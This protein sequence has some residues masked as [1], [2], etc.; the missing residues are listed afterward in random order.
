MFT[1]PHRNSNQRGAASLAVSIVLLF[2]MT[3]IAFFASRS[4]IFEQ[5][6]S[7][8][9]YRAARAF[10][11]A[12][13]GIEW[14]LTQINQKECVSATLAAGVCNPVGGVVSYRDR[15]IAPAA[16]GFAP[17]GGRRSG[18][19]LSTDAATRVVS[20]NCNAPTSNTLALGGAVTDPRFAIAWSAGPDPR[21]VQ[22]ISTGCLGQGAP[23]DGTGTPDAVSV[24]RV[25]LRVS[26]ELPSAPGAGLTTGGVA[27]TAGSIKVV[28][29]D[30]LS[31]G[32][33]INSGSAVAIASGVDLVTIEGS[34][35][36]A[37]VLDNDTALAALA[38][39]PDL[40]FKQYF[41]KIPS[42][43]RND[44]GTFVLNGGGSAF[45]ASTPTLTCSTALNCGSAVSYYM[46]RGQDKFW[47]QGDVAF[48]AS[49]MPSNFGGYLGDR[50][51]PLYLA[52]SGDIG[53][54]A[55]ITAFGLFYAST[56]TAAGNTDPTGTGSATIFGALVTNGNFC[57]VNAGGNCA[58]PG[59]GG[60]GAGNL[61]VVYD[62]LTL[63]SGPPKGLL[64]RVPG[65][66]RDSGINEL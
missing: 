61:T 23:C 66:W 12:E 54:N 57:K 50:Q 20:L 25:L 45:A 16:G 27:I 43:W 31:N 14:A 38:T 51:R 1:S 22:L 11:T 39:D 34:S 32:I 13:A 35:L 59:A 24:V 5:R 56:L 52:S 47:V 18:C 2:G 7:A 62:P 58:S 40:F 9:Q 30:K 41:G 42:D 15:Y 65:S 64:V 49:T 46:D 63:S 53:F 44:T 37:S 26:P 33:T 28:N 21:T 60:A 48:N 10:E 8:N 6:T 55:N 4:M 3:L 17:P 36:R 29:T 19:S